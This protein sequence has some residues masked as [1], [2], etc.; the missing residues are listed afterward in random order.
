MK[1]RERDKEEW[2]V[3]EYGG[4]YVLG[5]TVRRVVALHNTLTPGNATIQL[6]ASYDAPTQLGRIPSHNLAILLLLLYHANGKDLIVLHHACVR[7]SI[8]S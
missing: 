5:Q 1:E 8:P 6:K 7:H 2:R 3:R 4:S